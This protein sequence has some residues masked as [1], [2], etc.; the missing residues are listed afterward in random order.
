MKLQDL[1][2]RE[3]EMEVAVKN[4]E[5]DATS[6]GLAVWPSDKLVA[7]AQAQLNQDKGE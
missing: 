3:E 4:Q 2:L 7:V 1:L 5:V 6:A